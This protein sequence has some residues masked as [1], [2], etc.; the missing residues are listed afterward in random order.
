MALDFC[1]REAFQ[2]RS[3]IGL[4]R[5]FVVFAL[6]FLML[7]SSTVVTAGYSV[8]GGRQMGGASTTFPKAV[9]RNFCSVVTSIVQSVVLMRRTIYHNFY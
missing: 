5:C 2:R 3:A 9:G 4:C 7:L 6:V 8:S 1:S